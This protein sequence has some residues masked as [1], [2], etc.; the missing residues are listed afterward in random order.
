[1]RSC[2]RFTR[3]FAKLSAVT[4]AGMRMRSNI[5]FAVA[6]SGFIASDSPRSSF[7]VASSAK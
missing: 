1:M 4:A 3:P 6:S 7:I 5:S 2:M